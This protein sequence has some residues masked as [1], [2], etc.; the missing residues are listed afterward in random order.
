MLTVFFVSKV[1]DAHLKNACRLAL[2]TKMM[3]KGRI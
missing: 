3:K 2:V 1:I